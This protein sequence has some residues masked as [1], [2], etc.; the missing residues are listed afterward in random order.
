[1]NTKQIDAAL[2]AA[3]KQN[4]VKYETA[5][6]IRERLDAA[7][8]EYGPKTWDEDDVESTILDLVTGEGETS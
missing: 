3:Q 4:A 8:R 2:A 5:K 7:R 1:M 6:H